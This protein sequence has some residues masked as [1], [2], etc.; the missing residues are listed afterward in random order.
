M[1]SRNETY[2]SITAS[3]LNLSIGNI[4]E[5]QVEEFIRKFRT[6]SLRLARPV[7]LL[8]ANSYFVKAELPLAMEEDVLRRGWADLSL[9]AE[10]E[11][12]D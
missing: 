7:L 6:L 12:P 10:V 1:V 9:E 4:E 11:L 2:L 5:E 3:H 8:P